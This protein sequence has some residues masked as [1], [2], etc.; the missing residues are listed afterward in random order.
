[1]VELAVLGAGCGGHAMAADLSLAGFKVN[2][3]ELPR[4][5][6]KI[7]AIRKRGG[8]EISGSARIGT[9]MPNMVTTDVKEAVTDVDVVMFTVPVYG[10]KTFLDACLP[11]LRN[12][13][14]LVF[15]TAYYAGL[16]FGKEIKKLDKKGVLVAETPSLIYLC[17][18]VAPAHVFVDGLKRFLQVAAF[19]AEDTGAVVDVLREAYPQLTPAGNVLET[20]LSNQNAIFHIPVYLA[21]SASVEREK[22]EYSITV[23]D[24]VTPSVARIMDSMDTERRALGEALGIRV[25]SIGESIRKYYGTEGRST[26]ELIQNCKPYSTYVYR[27]Q[28]GKNPYLTEDWAYGLIPMASLARDLRI[29]SPT[30]ESL[31]T[32][33]SVIDGTDYWREG[34]TTDKLCLGGL[35][36]S[37]MIRFVTER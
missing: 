21:N 31:I 34:L 27:F 19:P 6:E 8:I 14:I 17:R 35:N 22:A 16:R 20:S 15:N 13:Q 23:A 5:E 36:P 4:F 28:N 7:I 1:V 24:A 9:V 3:V 29:Q 12:G 26:Y 30:I 18:H 33:G 37:E 32:M 25:L 2:L 10:H 11:Y